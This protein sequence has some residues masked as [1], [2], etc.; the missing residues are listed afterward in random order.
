MLIFL[1]NDS[2]R[3]LAKFEM[4]F[5]TLRSTVMYYVMRLELYGK[6]LIVVLVWLFLNRLWE[7]QDCQL[8]QLTYDTSRTY[9]QYNCCKKKLTIPKLSNNFGTPLSTI[10]LPLTLFVIMYILN[11]QIFSCIHIAYRKL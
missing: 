9:N 3:V 1:T 4:I 2:S 6:Q 5:S 8:K 7:L 11:F 10:I